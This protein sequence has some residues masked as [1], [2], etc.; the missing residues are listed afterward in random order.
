MKRKIILK[1]ILVIIISIVALASLIAIIIL[2]IKHWQLLV[3]LVVFLAAIIGGFDLF[4]NVLDDIG[5][6]VKTNYWNNDMVG[7]HEG[8]MNS[9]YEEH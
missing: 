2:S 4:F 7:Q 9:K 6:P 5:M 3:A 8:D 1:L